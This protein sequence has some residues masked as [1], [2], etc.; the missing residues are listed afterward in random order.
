VIQTLRSTSLDEER[1]RTLSHVT[2]FLIGC[3]VADVLA[4]V[5]SCI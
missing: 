4:T 5:T 2:L 3:H 1:L